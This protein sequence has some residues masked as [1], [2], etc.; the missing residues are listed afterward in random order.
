MECEC[1]ITAARRRYAAAS[2]SPVYY[3]TGPLSTVPWPPVVCHLTLFMSYNLQTTRFGHS[4]PPN[5][6]YAFHL[7]SCKSI[8]VIA[9]ISTDTRTAFFVGLLICSLTTTIPPNAN[10]LIRAVSR[11]RKRQ[12]ASGEA[13]EH[14]RQSSF[15]KKPNAF[16]RRSY[17]H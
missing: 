17:Y 13:A 8:N 14:I 15:Y 7:T 2:V 1:L 6:V 9:P 3:R 5:S 11:I 10:S 16:S 4:G 12:S